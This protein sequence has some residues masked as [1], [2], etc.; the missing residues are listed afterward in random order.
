MFPR[1]NRVAM[2]GMIPV[3]VVNMVFNTQ[4][5]ASGKKRPRASSSSPPIDQGISF[6]DNRV[7]DVEAYLG[8]PV[9]LIDEELVD[10]DVERRFQKNCQLSCQSFLEFS[11]FGRLVG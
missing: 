9:A 3:I 1:R 2:A 5:G 4:R 8:Q 11:D 6:R 7:N 10:P